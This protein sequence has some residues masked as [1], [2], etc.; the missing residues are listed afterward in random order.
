MKL[1]KLVTGAAVA[2][3]LTAT[4]AMADITVVNPQK[5][6]GGTTVWTEIIMKELTKHLGERIVLRNIPGARDIPGINK[7]HNDLRFDENTIVV[8]HGGNGV[9]FLQEN[10]DYNYADYDS[11][12]LMNLNIIMGKVKGADMDKPVFAGTSGAVPEAFAI[13]MMIC[14]PDQTLDQYIECFGENVK[15]VKGMSG[16]E[17]RL[18]FKRGDLTGSR[19]NPA[20]YAIHIAPDEN[21]E[22]WFHHGL[23]DPATGKHVDDANFPGAQFEIQFK[24]RYGVEP[25]G[26]FY[27]AYVL[28]KSFRDGLQ[29]AIWVNKGNPELRDRL[30]AAMNKMVNDPESMAAIE[31]KNGKYEW[32]IGERGDQMRDTLMTFITEDAL[33]TLVAFN[34]EALGLKSVLKEDLFPQNR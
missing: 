8:T 15:W 19:E 22:L 23:L 18:A 10:V 31:A 13:A 21:A 12:G 1:T 29:K 14:G 2:L 3:T 25:S 28:V 32:F 17:R 6:G 34:T 26:E 24:E 7:W 20:T 4:A 27:D 9:S 30:V 33:R 16:G 11:I 5:P